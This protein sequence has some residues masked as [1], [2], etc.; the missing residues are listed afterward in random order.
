[1]ET[2]DCSQCLFCQSMSE[3]RLHDIM[4]DSKNLEVKTEF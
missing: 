4:Q 1:M 2:F 3:D